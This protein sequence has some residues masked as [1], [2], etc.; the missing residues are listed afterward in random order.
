LESS[1]RES[2]FEELDIEAGIDPQN[3]LLAM[4]KYWR[5][6]SMLPRSDGRLPSKLLSPKSKA[7]KNERLKTE[8]GTVPENLF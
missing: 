5:Y 2:K 1:S 6:G 8:E 4:L 3:R 7:F